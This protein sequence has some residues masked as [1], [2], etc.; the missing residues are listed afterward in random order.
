MGHFSSSSADWVGLV[1]KKVV[2]PVCVK[3]VGACVQEGTPTR[4][5]LLLFK[6]PCSRI[7]RIDRIVNFFQDL[8]GFLV[9]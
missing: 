6:M 9:A 1:E 7:D 5:E 2:V 4:S 8:G 3:I